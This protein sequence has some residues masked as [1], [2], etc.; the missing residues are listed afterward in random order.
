MAF[1][2]LFGAWFAGL[3]VALINAK[4]HPKELAYILDNC[5]ASVLFTDIEGGLSQPGNV[6]DVDGE[7]YRA[8][9]ATTPPD[10]QPAAAKPDDNA[11][12]FYTS[13]TTGYPK[14]AMLTHRNLYNM[15]M[16]FLADIG[17]VDETDAS[18]YPAPLSHGAGLLALAHLVRGAANVVP[19]SGGFEPGEIV[20]LIN[21]YPGSSFFAAPTMVNRLVTSPS[22]ADLTVEN[23]DHIFTA[24]PMYVED[25]KRALAA[26][27]PQLGRPTA[28]ANPHHHHLPPHMHRQRRR[29]PDERLS[30]VALAQSAP[31]ACRY[32]Q[33]FMPP[34]ENG[35]SLATS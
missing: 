15:T 33:Q 12:L 22:M 2:I 19:E 17:P 23:L 20:D 25:L 9:L 3:A 32:R 24:A 8:M 4:L 29:T 6:V 21:R 11:W 35:S 7:A 27:G 30:S 26:L 10:L 14:G 34:G 16:S 31:S 1:E 5:A 18:L 28:R 13:G